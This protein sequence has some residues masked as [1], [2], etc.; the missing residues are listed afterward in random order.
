MSWHIPKIGHL[1]REHP[2]WEHELQMLWDMSLLHTPDNEMAHAF[3]FTTPNWILYKTQNPQ[4]QQLINKA[5]AEGSQN[6]RR[7]QWQNALSGNTNMQ[8]WLGR[9]ILGQGKEDFPTLS[10][11][12]Q[13]S[14]ISPESK[15]HLIE[16]R[17]AIYKEDEKVVEAE[18]V[19]SDPDGQTQD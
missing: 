17:N 11:P 2:L 1:S 4:I 13:L 6:L 3:S 9:H 19:E 5:R 7:A 14:D 16:L 18:L 12:A 15:Q 8:I 10:Q